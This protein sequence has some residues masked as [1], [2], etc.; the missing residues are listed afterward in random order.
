MQLPPVHHPQ[1]HRAEF[2]IAAIRVHPLRL[3]HLR[4][5][6]ARIRLYG[7]ARAHRVNVTVEFGYN[8]AE[9]DRGFVVNQTYSSL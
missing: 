8:V 1:A 5:N 3:R 7:Q 2:R 9:L 6:E 4:L